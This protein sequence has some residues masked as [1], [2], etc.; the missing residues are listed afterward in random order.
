MLL[1]CLLPPRA[2]SKAVQVWLRR[3]KVRREEEAGMGEEVER[4]GAGER[5]EVGRRVQG[6]ATH[7]SPGAPS[8]G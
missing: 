6:G 3:E 5:K 7:H 8:A 4:G 2:E 1:W